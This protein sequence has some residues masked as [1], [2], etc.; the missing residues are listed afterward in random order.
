MV[1]LFSYYHPQKGCRVWMAL[2]KVCSTNLSRSN[3][4]QRTQ[5]HKLS[6]I[7]AVTTNVGREGWK[8]IHLSQTWHLSPFSRGGGDQKGK[9]KLQSSVSLF[10]SFP[11][12]FAL[13]IVE[14]NTYLFNDNL[15]NC[16]ILRGGA[17]A[18]YGWGVLFLCLCVYGAGWLRNA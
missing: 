13:P 7:D 6:I 9:E 16:Q 8:T 1:Y 3:Y 12:L 14:I 10:W 15:A 17:Q 5:L 4:L 2:W 11:P 18:L